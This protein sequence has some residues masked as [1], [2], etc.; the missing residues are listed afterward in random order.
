MAH[1]AAAVVATA[2]VTQVTGVV[3]LR[4]PVAAVAAA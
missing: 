4:L 3:V 1:L 2:A